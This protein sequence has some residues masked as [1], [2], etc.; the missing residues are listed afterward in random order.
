MEKLVIEDRVLLTTIYSMNERKW[1]TNKRGK[2]TRMKKVKLD[3]R[4]DYSGSKKRKRSDEERIYRK[5]LMS[6][7]YK[8]YMEMLEK[9]LERKIGEKR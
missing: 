9:K 2:R 5:S 4:M 7:L 8:I 1:G 6:T 3:S